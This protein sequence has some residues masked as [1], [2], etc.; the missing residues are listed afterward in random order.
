MICFASACHLV[1]YLH[2]W[3]CDDENDSDDGLDELNDGD[4]GGG[5]CG[6]CVRPRLHCSLAFC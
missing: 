6:D 4:D 1:N 5:G 3:Q 2:C